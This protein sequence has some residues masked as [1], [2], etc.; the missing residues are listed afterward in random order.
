MYNRAIHIMALL[1]LPAYMLNEW[2]LLEG[3]WGIAITIVIALVTGLFA[4]KILSFTG[5]RTRS[6]EDSEEF[7][8]E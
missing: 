3:G 8:G 6:Y 5:H 7:V 2:I 4:G 1:F